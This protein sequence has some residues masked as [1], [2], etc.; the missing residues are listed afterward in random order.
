MVA[1]DDAT[2]IVTDHAAERWMARAG[3]A[4][5]AEAKQAV[6]HGIK[7]HG[8]LVMQSWGQT[9]YYEWMGL[10]FPCVPDKDWSG[11]KVMVVKT[12][13]LWGMAGGA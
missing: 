12:T 6:A 2:I 5:L 1:F 3:G 11:N 8:K 9:K 13:L 10:I 7:T 4:T